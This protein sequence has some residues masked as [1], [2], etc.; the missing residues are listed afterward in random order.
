MKIKV[1]T[2]VETM[3]GAYVIRHI[4]RSMKP[5]L[6]MMTEKYRPKFGKKIYIRESALE[7]TLGHSID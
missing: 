5:A 7:Y 1:G 2:T 3:K 4:N 6:V